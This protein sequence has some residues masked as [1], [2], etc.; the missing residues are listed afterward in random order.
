[1]TRSRRKGTRRRRGSKRIPRNPLVVPDLSRATFSITKTFT[2]SASTAV[3]FQD[4]DAVNFP[5]SSRLYELFQP[6]Q[7]YRY[8]KLR[9][10]ALPTVDTTTTNNYYAIG[11]SPYSEGTTYYTTF[12]Q[13]VQLMASNIHSTS[14]TVPTSFNVQPTI[15]TSSA[16]KMFP[17]ST[18][19]TTADEIQGI[20]QVVPMFSAT[21]TI[22]LKITGEV[23]FKVA[24]PVM[25]DDLSAKSS[26]LCHSNLQPDE[27][28]QFQILLKKRSRADKQT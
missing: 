9:I 23:V 12:G 11:Y 5:S 14:K 24:Q 3:Q 8:T 15:L 6:W 26:L 19:D 28:S 16:Q 7:Y 20:I 18:S 22:V 25:S 27:E 21:T 4:I 17:T 1:M 2:F 13:V 10:S